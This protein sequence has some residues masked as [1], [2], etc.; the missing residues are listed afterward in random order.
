MKSSN[1]E[2]ISY[3]VSAESTFGGKASYSGKVLDTDQL[4]ERTRTDKERLAAWGFT[5]NVTVETN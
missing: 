3:R 1:P 4:R 2:S 5:E